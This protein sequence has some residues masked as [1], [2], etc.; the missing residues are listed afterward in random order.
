ML[1]RK[2]CKIDSSFVSEIFSLIFKSSQFNKIS[3]IGRDLLNAKAFF[4]IDQSGFKTKIN[5]DE[6]VKGRHTK[7]AIDYPTLPNNWMPLF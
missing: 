1:L 7:C 2:I 4:K 5:N 3:I 6:K